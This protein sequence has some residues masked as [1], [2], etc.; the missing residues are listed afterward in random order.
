[1]TDQEAMIEMQK[2][3]GAALTSLEWFLL[4]SFLDIAMAK[5]NMF[6]TTEDVD[7]MKKTVERLHNQ[8][9]PPK[10]D[11]L[12]ELEEELG[13]KPKEIIKPSQNIII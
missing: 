3:V 13:I 1:M 4:F 5:D 9:F 7:A 10:K 2:P 12:K 8:V 11:S 6:A